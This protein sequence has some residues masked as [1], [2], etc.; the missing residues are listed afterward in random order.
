MKMMVVAVDVCVFVG[1]CVC[2]CVSNVNVFGCVR[3]FYCIVGN[4]RIARCS[5]G[6][7]GDVAQVK[8]FFS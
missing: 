4:A 1:V 3:G 8:F 2:V 6:T 5:R 7:R